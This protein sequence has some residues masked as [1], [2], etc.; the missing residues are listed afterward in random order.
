MDTYRDFINRISY[1]QAELQIGSGYFKPDGRVYQKVACDNRFKPFWG[2]TVVFDLDRRTKAK[3]AGIID[4]LYSAVPECFCEQIKEDTIHMT[5]HDLSTSDNLDSIAPEMFGNEIELL[6][7]LKENP[8]QL[9]SI[10]MKTNYIINMVS[11]SL[12]LAL[13]PADEGEWNKLQEMYELINRV[14]VCPYPYLTPHITLAYFNYNGFDANSAD[15]LKAKVYELN[16]NRFDIT[17]RTSKLY[18]QKFV[19]MNDFYLVFPFVSK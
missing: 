5:L 12:V 14:K 1:Q 15:K 9:N 17:L 7:V 19:S 10:K 3:I 4:S 13:V 2:D 11:T 16:Q 6:R 8:Q 18:Y